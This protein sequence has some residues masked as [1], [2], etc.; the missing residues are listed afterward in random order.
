MKRSSRIF[1]SELRTRIER[2]GFS[3]EEI[4]RNASMI[5]AF[6]SRAVGVQSP[7]SDLDV[8]C[9]GDGRRIKSASLDLLW[10]DEQFRGGDWLG[11]ELASHIAEYG[12]PI[13]GELDWVSRVSLS[14]R[15]LEHKRRRIISMLTNV[16]LGWRK[17]HPLFRK[18]YQTT[19]R[20]ELQRA[21]LLSRQVPVPPTP[22]LD[23]EWNFCSSTSALLASN[24]SDKYSARLE[25]LLRADSTDLCR[26]DL[27][28]RSEHVLPLIDEARLTLS[29]GRA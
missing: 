16:S 3:H 1:S 26:G 10:I 5:V 24:W 29:T 21:A 9:F 25:T 6:G 17:L 28:S 7:T 4:L 13:A 22:V 11:S 14:E 15:A 18:R 12:V 2:E 23:A 27:F 8:L 19:L 20:R